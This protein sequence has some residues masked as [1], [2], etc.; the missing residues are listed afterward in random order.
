MIRREVR[1]EAE[2]IFRE[3][4]EVPEVA[5]WNAYYYLTESPEG[6]GFNLSPE[7]IQLLKEAVV[8]RYLTIIERDLTVEN[9][10]R[11]FYR[12]VC[13]AR[14]NWERLSKFLKRQGFSLGPFR[15]RLREK[16]QS[17]LKSLSPGNSLYL[18]ALEFK[19]ELEGGG[20]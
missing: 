4:G 2:L 18:E 12:G 1:E 16:L 13:R 9:I 8:R 3:G 7:E 5:F 14:I 17:F 11:P 20:G 10:G 6:P 15:E 19:K